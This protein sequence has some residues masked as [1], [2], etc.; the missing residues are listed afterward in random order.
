METLSIKNVLMQRDDISEQE[1]EELI[2]EA[3]KQ[4]VEYL[5]DDDMISAMNI[6]EEFF[7]LEQDYIVEL[8]E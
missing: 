5:N 2:S 1:V 8:Y 7:G 3:K 6:C 4:L